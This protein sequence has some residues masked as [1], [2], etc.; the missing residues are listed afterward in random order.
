[1]LS[2]SFENF[3][4]ALVTVAKDLIVI[5]AMIGRIIF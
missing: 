1:M 4:G 3:A 5:L 2:L